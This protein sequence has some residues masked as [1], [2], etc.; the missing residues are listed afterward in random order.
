MRELFKIVSITKRRN[1]SIIPDPDDSTSSARAI[2][3]DTQQYRCKI[4]TMNHCNTGKP[5]CQKK[6]GLNFLLKHFA[7]HLLLI[8]S[9]VFLSQLLAF[10]PPLFRAIPRASFVKLQSSLV[11]IMTFAVYSS[12]IIVIVLLSFIAANRFSRMAKSLLIFFV[13]FLLIIQS[14]RAYV[15][16]LHRRILAMAVN[17]V[18]PVISA[19]E[20]YHKDKGKYPHDLKSLVPK[21]ISK[22]PVTRM[23]AAYDLRFYSGKNIPLKNPWMLSFLLCSWTIKIELF[24][25]PSKNYDK[26]DSRFTLGTVADWAYFPVPIAFE[27]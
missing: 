1:R 13:T 11:S 27:Q 14:I 3:G 20:S 15:E 6:A 8:S 18:T 21:Y 16:P 4:H 24:Y 23:N 17:D 10:Y 5:N 7:G 12:P 2:C 22:I 25:L 19:I 9:L 26:F